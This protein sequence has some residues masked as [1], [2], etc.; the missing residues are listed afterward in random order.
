[1]SCCI[2][3]I[4]IKEELNLSVPLDNPACLDVYLQHICARHETRNAPPSRKTRTTPSPE[5]RSSPGTNPSWAKASWPPPSFLSK[6]SSRVDYY[7]K[8]LNK[9]SQICVRILCL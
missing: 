5:T 1:M 4:E 6:T 9:Q 7:D 3:H 2:A 8:C